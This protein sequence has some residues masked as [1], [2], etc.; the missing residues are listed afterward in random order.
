M[1]DVTILGTSLSSYLRTTRMACEEKG[2]SHD[3]EDLE[4]GSDGHAALHPFLKVPVMKH[5]DITL[6]ESLAIATYI[7]NVFAGPALVPSD[8]LALARGYQFIS[9]YIDHV[10]KPL[11]TD[12][13][14][15]RLAKPQ[16]GEQPDE[17]K[18]KERVPQC[19]KLLAVFDKALGENAFLAGDTCSLADLYLTTAVFYLPMVPEGEG[20][21]KDCP[22]IARWQDTMA[23]RESFAR[24]MPVFP[25]S[26]AAQ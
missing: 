9:A 4:F 15:E 16:R 2:I 3:L 6:Y 7:D 20:L 1:S 24:T 26:E 21:L 22:H 17:A 23:K 14:I 11:V 13:I 25:Q 19:A 8:A 12:I 10:Y 18:I 5:G